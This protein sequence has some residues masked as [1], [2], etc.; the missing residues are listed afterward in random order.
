MRRLLLGALATALVGCAGAR[1]AGNPFSDET[2]RSPAWNLME[3]DWQL[4]L[5]E[6]KFLE[7]APME[8]A[9]PAVDEAS[10]RVVA[11]TRDGFVRCISPEGKQEWSLKTAAPFSSGPSIYDG[12]V[13]VPGGDGT[14]YAVELDGGKVRWTFSAGQEL[15][16]PPLL[17][18]G[19][20][21]FASHADTIFALDAEKGSWKWQYRRDP[22]AGFT[23]RGMAQ[24]QFSNGVL[25]TGF[26]DGSVVALKAADG[27]L[28]WERTLGSGGS[29]FLDV[30]AGPILDG[31]GGLYVASYR[32]GVYALEED[33]GNV[34]WHVA[35]PGVTSVVQRGGV[36]YTAGEDAV[37]ALLR[38]DGHLIWAL[39]LKETAAKLPLL[40]P[41][42][43]LVPINRALLFVDPV[44]GKTG[45]AWDPGAGISAPVTRRGDRVYVLS[46]QGF[47]YALTL[48]GSAG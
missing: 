44:K 31:E 34:R 8:L 46:N 27:A 6:H 18:D 24:P 40:A 1:S 11:L 43:L 3:V 12:V 45:L 22:P 7:Y 17:A 13:Y 37:A 47:L 35:R 28:K 5:V 20:L 4:R 2:G 29:E 33:T 16:T 26:S 9:A 41:Q 32:D 38:E 48:K 10:G 23:V 36:L 14:L 42:G 30:D 15:A 25:Y 21:Y 39:P 19:V